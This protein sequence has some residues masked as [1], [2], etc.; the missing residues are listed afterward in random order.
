MRGSLSMFLLLV[1]MVWQACNRDVVAKA[2]CGCIIR[3]KLLTPRQCCLLV[4]F[5][6]D[7]VNM[8][9]DVP[10]DVACIVHAHLHSP[11]STGENWEGCESNFIRSFHFTVLTCILYLNICRRLCIA[12][13]VCVC[14]IKADLIGHYGIC[15]CML[16]A[17]STATRRQADIT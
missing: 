6:V 3:S 10:S 16:P 15:Q 7:H 11:L 2:F 1:H 8:L 5:M 4:M 12:Y 9:F 14:S 13:C 17:T